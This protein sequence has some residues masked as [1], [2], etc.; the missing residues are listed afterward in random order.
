ME[1]ERDGRVLYVKHHTRLGQE[2][3]VGVSQVE[4]LDLHAGP[5]A[6][7]NV[8]WPQCCAIACNMPYCYVLVLCFSFRLECHG[9]VLHCHFMSLHYVIPSQCSVTL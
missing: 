9:A 1:A 8:S 7:R 4:L 3:Q 2:A 5:H 6:T